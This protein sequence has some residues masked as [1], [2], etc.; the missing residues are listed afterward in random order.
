VKYYQ[1]LISCET[2]SQGLNI[3]D[4]LLKKQLAFGGPVLSGPAR[5]LWKGDSS[6]IAGMANEGLAMSERKVEIVEH[7][8]C[9]ALT[10][11]REDLRQQLIAEA[12]R[13]SVEEVCMVS[14][15]PMEGSPALIRLLDETFEGREKAAA[16]KY[17]DAMAALTFVPS[18]EIP[19]RTKR[20]T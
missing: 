5:F 2:R 14:F 7:D 12:E 10:Y 13:V 9:F 16:P 6:A 19:N 4:H 20:S 17:I 18:S 11:T 15:L 8:Y 1:T 3:L